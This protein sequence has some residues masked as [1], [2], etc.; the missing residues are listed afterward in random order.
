MSK[1]R[2]HVKCFTR[3][4]RLIFQPSFRKVHSPPLQALMER[5]EWQILQVVW[6]LVLLRIHYLNPFRKPT[7]E[8]DIRSAI[9][10]FE[11]LL[12]RSK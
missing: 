8:A 9:R 12:Q 7:S 10:E 1:L 2:L 11:V 4:L 3:W 5:N 6:E